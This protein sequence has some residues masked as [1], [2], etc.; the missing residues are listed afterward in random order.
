MFDYQQLLNQSISVGKTLAGIYVLFNRSRVLYVGQST[1]VF[2]RVATHLRDFNKDFDAYTLVAQFEGVDINDMEAEAIM[3][4]QPLQNSVLPSNSKFVSVP[5]LKTSYSVTEQEIEE[6]I[7][8]GKIEAHWFKDKP[9]FRFEA[10]PQEWLERNIGYVM[11]RAKG[12]EQ[13]TIIDI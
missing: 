7:V 5:S 12:V 11:R 6:L 3:A 10:L 8:T 2:T 13:V 4:L 9:Y 1:N